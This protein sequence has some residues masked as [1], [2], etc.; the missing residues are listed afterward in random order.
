MSAHTPALVWTCV[1]HATLPP[2]HISCS[3]LGNGLQAPSH[4]ICINLCNLLF[5]ICRK[6]LERQAGSSL[7][8]I[9]T[10]SQIC[11]SRGTSPDLW[12]CMTTAHG[13]TMRNFGMRRTCQ[14]LCRHLS[15]LCFQCCNCILQTLLT[16]I[17]FNKSW[18]DI[19]FIWFGHKL[20]HASA[21]I[22]YY[23]L[24]CLL[25]LCNVSFEV[26]KQLSASLSKLLDSIWKSQLRLQ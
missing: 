17:S 21:E 4:G 3:I 2:E 1:C 7:R 26:T 8:R 6:T 18:P 10:P 20:S 16:L 12:P 11:P 5:S 19:S 22:V 14:S 25:K 13:A 15:C 24:C 9:M 23:M